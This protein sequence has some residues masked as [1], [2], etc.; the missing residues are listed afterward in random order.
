MTSGNRLLLTILLLLAGCE[1]RQLDAPRYA[2]EAILWGEAVNGLEVGIARRAYEAGFAP[3][4]DQDYYSIHLRNVTKKDLK[5][6]SPVALPG[7]IPEDPAGDESVKVVLT[8]DSAAGVK[9]ASFTPPKKPVVQTLEPGRILKLELRLSASKFGM[10]RFVSGK[11]S[12]T[13]TN[14]QGAIKYS[15]LGGES[16]GG[17]WTGEARSGSVQVDAPAPATQ[18][19]A[20]GSGEKAN[21]EDSTSNIEHRSASFP[22][23]LPS[24]AGGEGE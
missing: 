12:A 17:L 21:I 22:S 5:V 20:K 3:G 14:G 4:K 10:D 15:T 23:P 16:V 6:L 11:I 13:Y 1:G 2:D 8:Y 7:Y 9:T 24:P 19:S 18:K